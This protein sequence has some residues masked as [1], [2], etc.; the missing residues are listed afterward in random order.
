MQALIIEKAPWARR[1]VLLG[2]VAGAALVFSS[3]F[4]NVYTAPKLALVFAGISIAAAIRL[5]E[6]LQGGPRPNYMKMAI[7]ALALLIPLTVSWAFAPYRAWSLFGQSGRFQGLLPYIAVILLGVLVADAFEGRLRELAWVLVGAGAVI[8]AFAGIQYLGL[9]PFPLDPADTSREARSTMGNSNFTGGVLGM[10]LPIAVVLAMTEQV[11]QR[12]SVTF[13]SLIVA[14]LILSF[15]QGGLAAAAAGLAILFGFMLADKKPRAKMIGV[16]LAAGIAIGIVLL[17]TLSIFRFDDS[18]IPTT[19]KDRGRYWQQAVAMGSAHPIIG[20][21]PNA[22]AVE[23]IQYRPQRDASSVSPFDVTNDPHS[24]FLAL[25]TSAGVLGGAGFLTLVGWLWWRGRSPDTEDQWT[26]AFLGAS[27][28][29]ITQ[30]LVSIDEVGLRVVGWTCI[31]A[32][33]TTGVQQ[34]AAPSKRNRK[35][36]N[37]S[38]RW[39]KSPVLVAVAAVIAVLGVWGS[40]RFAYADMKV[41]EA[42]DQFTEIDYLTGSRNFESAL[43]VRNDYHYRYL[44]GFRLGFAAVD[45]GPEGQPFADDRDRAF[46]YLRDFPDVNAMRDYARLLQQ[47]APV[48]PESTERA[49]D[50]YLRAVSLDPINP[51]LTSEAAGVLLELDRVDEAEEVVAAHVDAA[52]EGSEAAAAAARAWGSAALGLAEREL[53]EPAQIAIDR[54]LALDPAQADATTAT[55]ILESLEEGSG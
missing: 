52:F 40:V 4:Y 51:I 33:A 42:I 12:R 19:I 29:Y 48:E 26:M 28:A 10:I 21:G 31:G 15:S 2:T 1:V 41:Q 8:G 11:L 43:G 35:K 14:G 16:T 27:A 32:L 36:K 3:S 13:L 34:A 7:P 53:V 39:L 30:A 17:V 24:V 38:A 55:N 47:W 23:G 5:F 37:A 45:G 46:A 22:F 44:F 50:L 49:A 25:F 20:R 9:D 6:I 54:A 18:R